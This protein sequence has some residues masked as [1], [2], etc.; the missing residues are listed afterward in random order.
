MT[1]GLWF[2]GFY[3]K[4]FAGTFSVLELGD[5]NTGAEP[6]SMSSKHSLPHKS[7]N[8]MKTIP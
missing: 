5:I 8:P 7:E 2:G 3:L 6:A 4:D 1:R